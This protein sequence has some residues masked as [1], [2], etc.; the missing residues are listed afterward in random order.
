MS[1]IARLR[2]TLFLA[3]AACGL[4][5]QA[6]SW[7]AKPVHFVVVNT[8]GSTP[9]VLAR[10]LSTRLADVWKQPVVID[11]R[12]GGGGLLAAENIVKSPADGYA[13]LVGA[14]GPIT[15]LP[16]LQPGLPYNALH[17]LVPVVSL[18]KIDFVLV[19]NPR[20]GF[21]TLKDLV[22][23]A[24]A[25]P[26]KLNYASA[27]N[28]SPQQLGMEMLKQRA[29]IFVTHIPYRGG[30]LGLQDVLAGQV[31]VM[32]IAIGP[33]LAQIRS[34]RLVALAVTGEARQPLLSEVP[35]VAETYPGF[36]AG[37]WFGLFAP[38]RTPQ[39][40]IETISA[41]VGRLVREP[42]VRAD[43]A[44]QGIQ[45]TG[46]GPQLFGQQVAAE[47]QRYARIVGE[48]GIKSD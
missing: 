2:L 47:Y 14:D 46:F 9:D 20:T 31:D 29:G 44:A 11:N 10:Y 43:F 39:A 1:V 5:V 25:R 16:N 42:K 8:A 33:A 17:D 48:V 15:I 22:E 19:A 12:T 34:G 6:Q 45:A 35:T 24:K 3:T 37:T 27:G 18:G 13:L 38:A 32:F 28:A 26:G 21:K 36:C 23:A 4:S 41:D 40:V 7:P 30:S